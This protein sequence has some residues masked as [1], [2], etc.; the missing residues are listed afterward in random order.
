MIED[1]GA[2]GGDFHVGGSV[3][4]IGDCGSDGINHVH[5]DLEILETTCRAISVGN[6]GC[7]E[8]NTGD[9]R[10]LGM[11]S[12]DHKRH[13]QHDLLRFWRRGH[14]MDDVATCLPQSKSFSGDN[15]S[16]RGFY[17]SLTPKSNH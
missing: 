15:F 7:W 1:S 17:P 8:E 3:T 10:Q 11:L 2:M 16:R 13:W 12:V 4:T 6:L 9:I 14:L 5:I